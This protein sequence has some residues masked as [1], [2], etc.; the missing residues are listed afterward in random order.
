MKQPGN[1]S[2]SGSVLLGTMIFVLAIAAFLATYLYFVQNSNLGV[3]RAQQ[4]NSA[5]AIAEAVQAELLD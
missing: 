5:L 3:A 4:W 1:T 2:N